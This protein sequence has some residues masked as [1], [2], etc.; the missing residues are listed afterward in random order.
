MGEGEEGKN[1]QGGSVNILWLRW[2]TS[3]NLLSR[4][5]KLGVL[6]V[7]RKNVE[8]SKYMLVRC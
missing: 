4:N 2:S 6:V 1:I 5:A 8:K 3:R 7:I